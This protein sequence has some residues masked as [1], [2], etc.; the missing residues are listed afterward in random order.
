MNL[1]ASLRALL[2]LADVGIP[3]IF[4]TFPAMVVALV[5]VIGMEAL[6]IRRRLGYKPW[7]VFRATAVANLVSTIVGVPLTWLALVACE[8]FIGPAVS[9][10]PGIQ[11]WHG[12]VARVIGIMFTAAWLPP[13][14]ITSSSIPLAMLVLLVPFFFVSVWS[15]RLVMKHM[16]P[17]TAEEVMPEGQVSEQKLRRAVRD[18]NLLSYGFLFA[19]T[20]MVLLW[21]LLH[22]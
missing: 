1:L 18:A 13:W 19:L 15:E 21:R 7:P 11:N 9:R 17:V 20:C 16:L 2:V 22:K 4:V 14:G 6:L 10:I 3:M 5:P 12:P 8:T